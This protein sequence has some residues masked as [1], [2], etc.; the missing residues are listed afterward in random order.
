MPIYEYRCASCNRRS[1]IFVRSTSS[2]VK[3][4]CEH[5]GSAKVARL[6]SKFAV[7][8]KG[9]G[10]DLDDPTS[11]DGIDENDPKAVARWARQMKDEMG[12]DLGPEFDDMVGRIEAG[13]DPESVMGRE[14]DGGFDDDDF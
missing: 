9:G 14:D 8:G 13:E 7:H 10:F 6:M 12:E 5:C 4:K 3:P 1:S 11:M 2:A